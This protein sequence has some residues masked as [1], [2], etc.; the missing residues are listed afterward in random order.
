M[1]LICH[2]RL[3]GIEFKCLTADA[4]ESMSITC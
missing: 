4:G 3:Y 2:N 1:A